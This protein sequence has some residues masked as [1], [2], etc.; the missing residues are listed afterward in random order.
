MRTIGIFIAL[1]A[2]AAP[3]AAQTVNDDARC[4]LVSSAYA[5]SAKDPKA[6]QVAQATSAFYLGRVDG[7]Y[8]APALKTALAAQE[9]QLTVAGAPAAMNACAARVGQVEARLQA[10]APAPGK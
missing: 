10:L 5:R 7:R 4:L 9:K 6:R 1:A 3:A 8:P 2:I